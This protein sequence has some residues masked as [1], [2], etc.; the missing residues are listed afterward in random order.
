MATTQL[1]IISMLADAEGL[2]TTS[3]LTEM[4]HNLL[5]SFACGRT[6]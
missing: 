1:A 6:L 4:R 3:Q 5:I 2:S